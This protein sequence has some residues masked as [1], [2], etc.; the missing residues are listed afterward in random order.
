MD[1]YVVS[2]GN[3]VEPQSVDLQDRLYLNDGVGNFS[4][5]NND[6]PDMRTSGGTVTSHDFD[7][8]GDIDLFVGGRVVPGAYPTP[9]RSYLLVNNGGKFEDRTAYFAP[10]LENPGMVTSSLWVDIDN[11]GNKDLIVVGEWMPIM[12]MRYDGEFFTDVS[13]KL[14]LE[15]TEG[16]WNSVEAG[17]F[18][19]DGDQ[20]LVVGNL[21][22]NYKYKTN[23]NETF[24]IHYS[25]FDNSGTGDIVLSYN[26][27]GK[28]V[29]LRGRECSSQQMPFIKEKF[30]TYDAFGKATLT[31]VY[32]DDKLSLALHLQ[33][34][35]F[36]SVYIENKMDNKWEMRELPKLAQISSINGIVIRDLNK[37]GNL[38]MVVSGNLFESE[39]ETPRNDASNGL[40][41]MGNG[42]GSFI[43]K[44]GFESGFN[45]PGNVKELHMI[46]R[47]NRPH[48]AVVNNNDHIRFF[49]INN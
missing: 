5:S 1:L 23:Q 35:T 10:E 13:K 7:N 24:D 14:G 27:G 33:A 4:R 8:D 20:D 48:L 43:E 47:K 46:S 41:L 26:E 2:G 31:D 15:D 25:D 28:M 29:P 17:D 18:D 30:K 45:A 40:V 11:D 37:D 32:G 44:L 49:Y 9:P 42:N 19:N 38:D 6:L 21:G 3:E 39:V 34:K 22:Q 12:I 16:W 36:A